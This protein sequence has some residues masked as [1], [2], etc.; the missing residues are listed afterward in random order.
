MKNKMFDSTQII[1][2]SASYAF[3]FQLS[4]RQLDLKEIED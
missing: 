3:P 4:K 1:D 2:L